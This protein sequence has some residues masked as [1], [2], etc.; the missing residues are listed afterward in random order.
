MSK[1]DSMDRLLTSYEVKIGDK[2]RNRHTGD[3]YT[4][5]ELDKVF[6]IG[7]AV[8]QDDQ[9]CKS[10]WQYKYLAHFEIVENALDSDEDKE[11]D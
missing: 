9:M 11:D 5:V 8:L 2:I 4:V 10:R 6:D 1:K 7:V 3:E